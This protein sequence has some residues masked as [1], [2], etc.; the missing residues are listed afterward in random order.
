MQALLALQP[1]RIKCDIVSDYMWASVQ[2][3]LQQH[4]QQHTLLRISILPFYIDY[5]SDVINNHYLEG[6]ACRMVFVQRGQTRV[7]VRPDNCGAPAHANDLDAS[8][9]VVLLRGLRQFYEEK[10]IES[11]ARAIQ[12]LAK[13]LGLSI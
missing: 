6:T 1:A 12:Q 10:G 4:D 11:S 3:Y 9:A 2:L 8:A 13:Q 5:R 7:Y